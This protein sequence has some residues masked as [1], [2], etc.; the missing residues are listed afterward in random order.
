MT[1]YGGAFSKAPLLFCSQYV[2]VVLIIL[3]YI[4]SEVGRGGVAS[5][6]F[7]LDVQK[8]RCFF[9]ATGQNKKTKNFLKKFKKSIDKG[10]SK[11]YNVRAAA[12]KV[13]IGP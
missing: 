13:A 2:G 7:G 3:H 5:F 1:F 6:A 8:W 11:W 10:E 12:K 4:I 9:V